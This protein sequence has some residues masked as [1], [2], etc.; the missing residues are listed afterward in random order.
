[1][2][3]SGAIHLPCRQGLLHTGTQPGEASEL[4]VFAVRYP[5]L[6][7]HTFGFV[8]VPFPQSGRQIGLHS[9]YG[10][11]YMCPIYPIYVVLS[12]YPSQHSYSLR[13]DTRD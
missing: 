2:Q 4:I 10:V 9:E 11:L 3:V 1:M 13:N 8:H 5:L 7:M 12:L 6:Q